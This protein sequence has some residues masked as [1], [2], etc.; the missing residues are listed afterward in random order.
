MAEQKLFAGDWRI[1]YWYPSNRREGDEE[2]SEY[3]A[4]AHQRGN[5]VIFESRPTEDKSYILL[6][7]AVDNDLATGVWEET[8]APNG[9]FAGAVYSGAVQLL[10]SDDKNHLDGKWVGVGQEQG[11]KRIYTG[12]WELTR[13][14]PSAEQ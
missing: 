7:L 3:E 12:R 11:K 4:T 6:R 8:T 13:Q 1:S 10:V 9:E 2:V 14:R 5:Q